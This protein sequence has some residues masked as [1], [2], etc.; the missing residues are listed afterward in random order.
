MGS[1]S[2]SQAQARPSLPSTKAMEMDMDVDRDSMTDQ[3]QGESWSRSMSPRPQHNAELI[4]LLSQPHHERQDHVQWARDVQQHL[5]DPH[6]QGRWAGNTAIPMAF[7]RTPTTMPNMEKDGDGPDAIMKSARP[8]VTD[9]PVADLGVNFTYGVVVYI[10]GALTFVTALA[11]RDALNRYFNEK[12]SL[13]NYGPW[14]GALII[15][16]VAVILVLFLSQIKHR[17]RTKFEIPLAREI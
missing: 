2:T 13:R 4:S 11:W 15:T 10:L 9:R 16:G 6:Q 12:H 7:S 3:R 14:A 17:I 1:P 8:S 5:A